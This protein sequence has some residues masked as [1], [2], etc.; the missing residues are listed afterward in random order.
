[1]LVHWDSDLFTMMQPTEMR[2]GERVFETPLKEKKSELFR[3]AR[4]GRS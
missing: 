2:V 1:M 3:T 4:D